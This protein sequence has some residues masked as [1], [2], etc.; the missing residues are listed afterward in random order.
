MRLAPFLPLLALAALSC[1]GEEQPVAYATPAAAAE[2]GA[3]ALAAGEH[4]VAVSAYEQAAQAP[5]PALKVDA[6]AG[7]YRAHLESGAGAA[8]LAA[9]K[10]LVAEGGELATAALLKSLTDAAILQRDAVTADAL[11][12]LALE[13]HPEA[14]ADFKKAIAAVDLLKTQGAGADLSSVG[15]AGD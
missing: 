13:K 9:A 12:T 10:R 14:Q 2:A 15:Y 7:L 8:A 4:A 6:L 1:G 3:R 11:L 5:E